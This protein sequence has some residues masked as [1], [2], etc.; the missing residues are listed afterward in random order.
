MSAVSLHLGLTDLTT[1]SL[2]HE[3]SHHLNVIYIISDLYDLAVRSS[4]PVHLFFLTL[5]DHI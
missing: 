5:P 2:L 4:L 3:I 1:F